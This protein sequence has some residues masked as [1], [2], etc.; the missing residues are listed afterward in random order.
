[1]PVTPMRPLSLYLL[2]TLTSCASINVNSA[3]RSGPQLEP[4]G[5]IAPLEM[6]E[7]AQ[8]TGMLAA[9]MAQT[10]HVEITVGERTLSG[11]WKP[12]DEHDVIGFSYSQ[13]DPGQLGFEVGFASSEDTDELLPLAQVNTQEIYAGLRYEFEPVG[14]LRPYVGGG[15]S[16][17]EGELSVTGFKVSEGSA[18]LYAHCGFL[19]DVHEGFHMGLDLRQLAFTD[20]EFSAVNLDLDHSQLGLVLGYSF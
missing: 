8:S 17:C 2:A 16:Y 10:K 1:M 20:A 15:F 4:P 5:G 12:K 7:A 9:M 19:V 13:C 11:D 6:A 14:L 3:Q 18:G